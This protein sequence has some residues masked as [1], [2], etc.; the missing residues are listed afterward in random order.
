VVHDLTIR[1][2]RSI[3]VANDADCFVVSEA[4]DGAGAPF[5][6]VF[7]AI[8]GTGVGGGQV[9]GQ[10]LVTGAN[11]VNG[12][13]GHLPLPYYQADD[14]GLQPCHCG[15]T[16]CMETLLSGGGL[17]RL[18]QFKHGLAAPVTASEIAA[19]AEQG[20][21]AALQTLD[22]YY[23][24][25]AKGLSMIVLCFDPDVIVIGGGLRDLPHL[26]TAVKS[27]IP[28]YCFVRDLKTA[29]VSA[30]YDSDSGVRGAAW[31]M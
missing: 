27:Y 3:K 13:W 4:L 6:H 5:H 26:Y 21:V 30:R 20:D 1:L 15:R 29:I 14:G 8:L 17:A 28:L 7:G 25:L 16:G 23:H 24:M 19:F 18:H 9:V 31:L 12:E 2:A 22:H 11:G 10:K